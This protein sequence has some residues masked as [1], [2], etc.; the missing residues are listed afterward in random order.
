MQK[1]EGVIHLYN[2]EM[3]VVHATRRLRLREERKGAGQFL[4]VCCLLFEVW[5]CI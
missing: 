3:K 4:G 1:K 2:P 5:C